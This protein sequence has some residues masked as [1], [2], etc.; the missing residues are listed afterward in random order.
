MLIVG[1]AVVA[2]VCMA[3]GLLVAI[4]ARPLALL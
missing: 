4:V 3:A 2:L 1:L